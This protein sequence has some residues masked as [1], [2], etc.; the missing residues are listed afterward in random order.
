VAY[1]SVIDQK[2][3]DELTL[4][5]RLHDDFIVKLNKQW[6]LLERDGAVY[7]KIQ[8]IKTE[9]GEELSWLIPFQG[10]SGTA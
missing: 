2:V 9:Y 4:I 7:H 10:D 6:L 1:L 5:N 8:S 3:D